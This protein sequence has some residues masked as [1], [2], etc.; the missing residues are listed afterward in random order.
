MVEE[1]YNGWA[2]RE[3]W[4]MALWLD[5]DRALYDESRGRA[6]EVV[7]GKDALL[8]DVE[9]ALKEW[10][11]EM[12][13]EACEEPNAELC[14][15]FMDI[16]SLYRVNWREVAESRFEEDELKRLHAQEDERRRL[17]MERFK[18]ERRSVE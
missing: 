4:A 7:E 8:I 13:G 3:T 9:D 10:V 1:R 17:R 5:N 14:K 12:A 15:M 6:R 18:A 16:G 2:N 11:N